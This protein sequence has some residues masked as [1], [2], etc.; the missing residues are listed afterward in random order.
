MPL[1]TFR[2]LAP[3]SILWSIRLPSL[4]SGELPD[5][6]YSIA[7]LRRALVL[8]SANPLEVPVYVVPG[9]QKPTS[10]DLS[11]D[12]HG[13]KVLKLRFIEEPLGIPASRGYG[14][15]SIEFGQAIGPSIPYLIC[16]KLGW[17][18]SSSTWLA[19]DMEYSVKS[20][21]FLTS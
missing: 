3:L 16:R 4:A 6:I 11:T 17:G 13:K 7:S 12:P 21:Y 10:F 1:I 8:V 18:S 15:P 2:V 19:R 14:Y 5:I 9:S 20:F